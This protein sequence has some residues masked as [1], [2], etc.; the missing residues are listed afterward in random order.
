LRPKPLS[1]AGYTLLE[2]LVVLTMLA[3]VSAIA[4]AYVPNDRGY[5]RVK[6][7]ADR[8]EIDLRSARSSA[9]FGGQTVAFSVDTAQGSLQYGDS[10]MHAVPPEI[11]LTLFTGRQLQTG[12]AAGA[13]EFFPNGE[14]SGGHVTVVSEGYTAQVDVDWLTGRVHQHLSDGP[15]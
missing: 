9:I 5:H 13:I 7:E 3:T 6:L 11:H 14:S 8:L 1:Q 2:L 10:A 15:K 4:I 12:D